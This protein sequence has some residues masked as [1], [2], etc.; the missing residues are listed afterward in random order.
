MSNAIEVSGTRMPASAA[1][2]RLNDH[3]APINAAPSSLR[4]NT[5]SKEG[6]HQNGE[7]SPFD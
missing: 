7:A 6:R 1:A 3:G 4:P 5:T 2:K